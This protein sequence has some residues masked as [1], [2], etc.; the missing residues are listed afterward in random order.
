MK[1]FLLILTAIYLTFFPNEILYSQGVHCAFGEC[2]VPEGCAEGHHEYINITRGTPQMCNIPCWRAPIIFEGQSCLYGPY[3]FLVTV[4]DLITGQINNDAMFGVG[5]PN[6]V[7]L[8]GTS[9]VLSLPIGRWKVRAAHVGNPSATDELI[10]NFTYPPPSVSWDF[11]TQPITNHGCHDGK[12]TVTRGIDIC[13][14]TWLL[15][16]YQFFDEDDYFELVASHI[17]GSENSFVKTGLGPGTY[18]MEYKYRNP[19]SAD[20]INYGKDETVIEDFICHN[21]FNVTSYCYNGSASIIVKFSDTYSNSLSCFGPADGTWQ[22]LVNG[23]PQVAQLNE[24]IRYDDLPPGTYQVHAQRFVPLPGGVV[25]EGSTSKTVDLDCDEVDVPGDFPDLESALGSYNNSSLLSNLSLPDGVTIINV[26]EGQTAPSG[27]Y[28]IGEG[29]RNSLSGSRTLK[30]KGNGNTITASSQHSAGSLNDAIF[31][32]VGSDSITITG[33]NMIENPLNTNTTPASN[34]MTEFGIAFLHDSPS[35]GCQHNT[36]IGNNISLN[37]NYQNTFGIYSNNRHSSSS[38][39]TVNDV[40]DSVTGPNSFNKIYSNNI[41]NVNF[42]I[43]FI[44]SGASSSNNAMD[45]GND[46]GGNYDSTANTFTNWGGNNLSTSAYVSL[47]THQFCI[48]MFNQ[49]NDNVSNNSITSA[50]GN[51]SSNKYFG[52]IYR[53]YPNGISVQPP[54][55]FTSNY[56]KNNI[57]IKNNSAARS[58]LRGIW[59]KGQSQS[60]NNGIINIDSNWIKDCEELSTNAA[61]GN[62]FTGIINKLN[63]GKLKISN[64]VI[65]GFKNH[66]DYLTVTGISNNGIIADSLNII[67]NKLGNSDSNFI[68]VKNIS[69]EI[70]GISNSSSLNQTASVLNISGNELRGI[71][72]TIAGSS[73]HYYIKNISGKESVN[74]SGNKFI[75]LNVN[76]SGNIYFI[77]NQRT[78]SV[79][80]PLSVSNNS[81]VNGF[82]KSAAGGQVYFFSTTGGIYR[83]IDVFDSNNFSNVNLTGNT[84]L[85]GWNVSK[86]GSNKTVTNNI[87]KNIS[88]GSGGISRILEVTGS[89][90]AGTPNIVTGNN[91]LNLNSAAGNI[92]GLYSA[93]GNQNISN[94]IIDSLSGNIVNAIKIDGGGIENLYSNKINFVKGSNA[95]GIKI[96]SAANSNINIQ[97]NFIGNI[98]PSTNGFS[99]AKCSGIDIDQSSSTVNIFYNTIYLSSISLDSLTSI[100]VNVNSVNAFI[101]LSNNIISAGNSNNGKVIAYKNLNVSRYLSSSNNNLFYAGTPSSNKLIFS[102][103]SASNFQTISD[104]KTFVSPRDSLSVT[105]NPNFISLISSDSKYLHIDSTLY[106]LSESGGKVISGINFDYE[107]NPRFP[108][109]GY[110]NN[111]DF[112][113]L[114]PDIGADEFGG[115]PSDNFG[116]VIS[117]SAL[118]DSCNRNNRIFNSVTINDQ[119]GVADGANKP[120]IYWKVNSSGSWSSSQTTSASSPYSFTIGTSGLNTGDSVY[121]FVIAQDI[122]NN[123][124][125]SPN[126]GLSAD[127][128]NNILSYP[129]NPNKYV[130]TCWLNE[131]NYEWARNYN[132]NNNGGQGKCVAVDNAGNSIVAGTALGNGVE[133]ITLK[134]N[135]AG[136]LQWSKLFNDPAGSAAAYDLVTDPAG[137]IYL[138]GNTGNSISSEK[139]ILT[140]KYSPAGDSLWVRK[141]NGPVNGNDAGHSITLDASGNVYVAGYSEG[142][143]TNKD[144]MIIKYDQNGN[145]IWTSRYNYFTNQDN[146]VTDVAIDNSGNV[147][148]TGECIYTGTA[149]FYL[150]NKYNSSGNLVWTRSY[151]APNV[152]CLAKALKVDNAGNVY[153]TGYGRNS[154]NNDDFITIKYGPNGDSLWVKLYNYANNIDQAVSLELV[155]NPANQNTPDIIVAGTSSSDFLTI[156]YSGDNGNV[157]WEK[158]YNGPANSIDVLNALAVDDLGNAYVTGSSF[159]YTTKDDIVTIKYLNETGVELW[160]QRYISSG[161][162]RDISYDIALGNDGSV[163]VAGEFIPYI[164]LILNVKYKQPAPPSQTVPPMTLNLKAFIQGFYNSSAN[165]QKQDTLKVTLRN[166]TSPYAVVSTSKAM[167]DSNGSGMFTFTNASNNTPYYLQLHHRNSIETWSAA[168]QNFISNS[169]SYDFTNFIDKAFGNNLKRVDNN[170]DRFAVYNGDVNQDG[171]I[172]I[173]DNELIEN[174]AKDFVSGYVNTD[175]SGDDF[176]DIIDAAIADNN[177][178]NYVST[179][180]P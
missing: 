25:C 7:N 129:T 56:N 76:T 148:V 133:I 21:A 15:N 34:N 146:F 14:N 108:N 180:R 84:I 54:L 88:C 155:N 174:D 99:S 36:I 175:L 70:T 171:T 87:F 60:S 107:G 9:A 91:I 73:N 138:T 126:A 10:V 162:V 131:V 71:V 166:N 122:L 96:G 123:V 75:D 139:N 161:S 154:S 46:I 116:P 3:S 134:Y 18:K 68:S 81:I 42:G 132:Y 74:I 170:P 62:E 35:D 179:V 156:K 101:G 61:T 90:T 169:L 85:E 51:I 83:T 89:D 102:N 152:L 157:K 57:S 23:Q 65:S 69:G 110:P 27:G 94:N 112:P 5:T 127:N 53:D 24:V 165:S 147:Y 121:Y 55:N 28:V 115:K 37:R 66:Q 47:P 32:L 153:V 125:A 41:S 135:Q 163:F 160:N 2:I 104:Y 149:T 45:N 140:I 20:W 118:T 38:I 141:Y 159:D 40:T 167:L 143:G 119:N 30:I 12:I 151:I 124:T 103:G 82:T 59:L 164:N 93:T 58:W 29:P 128:V 136:D 50:T 63:C 100:G 176:V 48:I 113:A 114:S 67:Q 145:E 97:N 39:T 64:N 144:Y 150:T 158:R 8:C 33:F 98:I 86:P 17:F 19:S 177:A 172:D 79:T 80:A 43:V 173:S 26:H 13:N 130:L 178:F 168:A 16:I 109:S 142:A 106:S 95:N 72:H 52:G 44:G 111:N 77:K 120:R 92:T 78:N 6:Y 105:E 31:K 11:I 49:Y 117:Y 1:T 137:N 4:T 22:C